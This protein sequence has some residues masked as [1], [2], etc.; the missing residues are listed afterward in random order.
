[1]GNGI[2][3]SIE[4]ITELTEADVSGTPANWLFAGTKWGGNFGTGTQLLFSFGNDSSLYREGYPNGEPLTVSPFSEAQKEKARLAIGNFEVVAGLDFIEVSETPFSAGDIR[5]AN[6]QETSTAHAYLPH[7]GVEAGDIWFNADYMREAGPAYEQFT[8][9]HELGHALGLKHPHDEGLQPPLVRD[10]LRYSVMSYRSYVGADVEQGYSNEFYPTTLMVDDI[11]VLQAMYGKNLAH[12]AGDTVYRWATG[13][14]I[15]ETLW[16]GGGTDTIDLSNDRSGVVI[17]LRAGGFSTAGVAFSDGQELRRDCLAIAYDC[18]IENAV[19]SAFDDQLL[20]NALSNVLSGGAGAD[21][22]RGWAGND[23]LWG[24]SGNDS[25]FGGGGVDTMIGGAGND[26]YEVN[27]WD[28]VIV[29]YALQGTDV[30]KSFVSYSLSSQVEHLD[31]QGAGDLRGTGNALDNRITG[32]AGSNV[33]TGGLGRD[34]FVLQ[35]GLETRDRITDFVSGT[36]KLRISQ[37]VLRLGD[38]DAVIDGAVTRTGPGGFSVAS[39]LVIFKQGV[40][41]ASSSW[42][43]AEVIGSATTAY[44]SDSSALFVVHDARNSAVYLFKS[45]GNDAEVAGEELSLL[46]TLSGTPLTAL[47]DYGF[48]I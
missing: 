8:Y 11:R 25:L 44:S 4:I 35:A 41:D 26:V 43:A 14:R 40:A 22:L 45:D 21:S 2:T 29:E 13:A 20:G 16:D 42:D 15:F 38:G 30:V 47:G 48:L 12:N 10:T 19:G 18:D 24:G 46:A 17:N 27:H 28:D 34:T 1:M 5:W 9:L 31:L 37:A 6:T 32:N 36:D 39:E 7:D 23:E 33:L 3:G